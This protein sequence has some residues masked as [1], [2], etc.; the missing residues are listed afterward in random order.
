MF[1]FQINFGLATQKIVRHRKKITSDDDTLKIKVTITCDRACEGDQL[2]NPTGE[3]EKCFRGL[4]IPPRSTSSDLVK[5][6]G[7]AT[8]LVMQARTP[9]P[10][11]GGD[12]AGRRERKQRIGKT[13]KFRISAKNFGRITTT[14][15]GIENRGEVGGRRWGAGAGRGRRGIPSRE[16][17]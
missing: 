17:L 6:V 4:S 3:N 15:L 13:N 11:N 7:C 10:T 1:S 12:E 2:N 16:Q 5:A 8:C 14:V 9:K